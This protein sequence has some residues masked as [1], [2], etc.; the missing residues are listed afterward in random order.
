MILSV[1]KTTTGRNASATLAFHQY[2]QATQEGG[3]EAAE[4]AQ[5]IKLG[6]EC[7]DNRFRAKLHVEVIQN[8]SMLGPKRGNRPEAICDGM[9]LGRAYIAEGTEGARKIA[10]R[11]ELKRWSPQEIERADEQEMESLGRTSALGPQASAVVQKLIPPGEGWTRYDDDMLMDQRSQIYFVQ[12]GPRRGQYLKHDP[13]S[14]RF[15]DVGVPHASKEFPI[16][17]SAG[18]GC[19]IRRGAKLDR[20]VVLNDIAKIAR[21]AL[22]FPL[23]FVDT[24]A[25]AYALF[26]GLRNSEAAQW[27]AENFHKKLLPMLADK[28]HSYEDDEL[29]SVLT[30]ALEALDAELLLGAGGAASAFSG[31]SSLV[32]LV[33]GRRLVVAGVG[34]VRAVLLPETG[35]P[36]PVLALCPGDFEGPEERARLQGVGGAMVRDGL[37]YSSPLECSDDAM[38]IVA[39][40]HVFEVFQTESGVPTDVK[41]IKSIYRKLA[42][43]V[44]PDK[45]PEGADPSIYKMAFAR[46]DSAKDAL[47]AMITEDAALCKELSRVLN[48]EVRTRAGAI[49]LLGTEDADDAEKVSKGLRKK[50]EKMRHVAPDFDRAEAV[51]CEA[52]A[53]LRRAFA[54]ESLPRHEALLKEGLS[55]S[56]AMGARDSRFPYPLVQ[57]KPDSASVHLPN[58]R[59]RVALLCGATA[60]FSDDILV[61]STARLARQPKASALRWCMDADQQ[62][63]CASALCISADCTVEG[64][65]TKRQRTSAAGPEGSVRVR[66]ILFAHLQLRQPD[67]MARRPGTA[68]TVQEAEVAALA[69]LEKL[70]LADKDPNVFL[71]ACRELSDCQSGSQPGALSGDLGWLS[72][73]QQET[74]F[75]DAA[76]SIGLKSFSDLVTSSRGV[77]IIQR[78]A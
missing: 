28:I 62:A 30:R 18:S 54:S 49:G 59:C 14:N 2:R 34:R 47:E 36:R 33:L 68:R 43:R 11:L 52:V 40:R 31:C 10:R 29:R 75:E 55:T 41:Q 25:C 63:A 32:A 15:E 26:Q 71:R 45:L 48:S 60:A 6:I 42:L 69:V 13:K 38:R 22:K 16:T 46:L 64:P 5:L 8:L 70:V 76:F 77:H 39:A 65:A 21:L 56:R 3:D 78:L 23:S 4:R 57:M 66:H 44:H 51:C 9:E 61:S 58:G 7:A 27:C 24:P 50:L 72:R 53:T 20:V 1:G 74:V 19:S 73:G 35:P 17:L 67:P 12:A 37:L